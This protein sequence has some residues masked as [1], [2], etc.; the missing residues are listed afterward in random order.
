MDRIWLFLAERGVD[1]A[2]R[3]EALIRSRVGRL[4]DYPMLGRRSESL[5]ARVLSLVDLQ[6]RVVYTI[7]DDQVLIAAVRSTKEGT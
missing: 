4:L 6:D 7:E 2:D 1:L 3:A 5:G